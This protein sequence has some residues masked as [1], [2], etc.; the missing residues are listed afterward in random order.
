MTLL[1][2]LTG[3]LCIPMGQHGFL[4]EHWVAASVTAVPVLLAFVVVYPST[5]LEPRFRRKTSAVFLVGLLAHQVEEHWRDSA[6]TAEFLH[7][8]VLSSTVFV[9]NA[10]MVWLLGVFAVLLA[11]RN[12][13]ISHALVLLGL[14]NSL[15]HAIHAAVLWEYNPG[16]ITALVLLL[17]GSLAYS[18]FVLRTQPWE[19]CALIVAAL[20]AISAHAIVVGGVLAT[21][22]F[23]IFGEVT[24]W[25]L[26]VGWSLLP[27]IWREWFSRETTPLSARR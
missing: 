18:A 5:P 19:R 17:P 22:M 13:M 10:S 11:P 15:I 24:L 2:L 21:G 20:W 25:T 26:I 14:V 8:S 3:I 9:V 4:V 27:V 1:L 16:L 12:P 23:E 7:G 6:N